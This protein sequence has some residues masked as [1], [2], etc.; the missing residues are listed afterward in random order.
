MEQQSVDSQ[1]D[2]MLKE[3]FELIPVLFAEDAI[4]KERLLARIPFMKAYTKAM[5]TA[6]GARSIPEYVTLTSNLGNVYVLTSARSVLD[7]KDMGQFMNEMIAWAQETLGF[8]LS[9]DE[10]AGRE[11]LEILSQALNGRVNQKLQ[12]LRLGQG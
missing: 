4:V 8:R 11:S 10:I 1:V 3:T 12:R 2:V 5:W 7:C 6:L 9:V